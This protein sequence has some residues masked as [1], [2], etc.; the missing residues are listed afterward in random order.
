MSKR[1]QFKAV[2]LG[3]ARDI[4]LRLKV[5]DAQVQFGHFFSRTVC[6]LTLRQRSK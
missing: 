5:G 1:C 4:N 3:F 2:R 6:E